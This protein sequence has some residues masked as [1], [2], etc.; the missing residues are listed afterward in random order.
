MRI[1]KIDS[2]QF[3]RKPD[4][5]EMRVYTNSLRK[6]TFASTTTFPSSQVLRYNTK[7]TILQ[8]ISVVIMTSGQ[9]RSC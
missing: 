4:A 8:P 7:S 6:D 1:T 5:H 9:C 2:T 3:Q